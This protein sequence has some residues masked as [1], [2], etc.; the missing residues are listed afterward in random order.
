M[1]L[2]SLSASYLRARPLNTLLSVRAREPASHEG[3]GWQAYTDELIALVSRHCDAV[4]FLL[5]GKFAQGKRPL[6]DKRHC[7]LTAAHP[8][9]YSAANGF[10]WMSP[11]FQG[12]CMA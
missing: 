12:Q 2:A 9:P 5:W 4:V 6:I 8:S 11:L 7:V 10:F 1:N 3:L